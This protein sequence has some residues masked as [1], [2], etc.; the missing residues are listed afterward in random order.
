VLSERA[1][2]LYK[3]DAYYDKSTEAGIIYNDPTLA[4]DWKIP[5][6]KE[7]VSDKDLL[8]PTLDK[9]ITNFE[10]KG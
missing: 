3:C 9:S 5:A 8:L 10:F 7:I 2:V 1:V 6:G 4:V